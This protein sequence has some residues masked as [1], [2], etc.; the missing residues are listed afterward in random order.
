MVLRRETLP[1]E[2]RKTACQLFASK[3]GFT[4]EEMK[5]F[6][7][8]EI[9][10]VVLRPSSVYDENSFWV[11]LGNWMERMQYDQQLLLAT[12]STRAEAFEYW[13]SLLPL[14]RQ[15]ELLLELCR[16]P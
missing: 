2:I 15:K 13:L 8:E 11:T 6:F 4:L 14:R 12:S 16:K 1:Y 10:K 5:V 9:R 3:T 7:N